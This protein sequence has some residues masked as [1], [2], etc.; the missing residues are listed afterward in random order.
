MKN[1][2]FLLKIW[3]WRELKGLGIQHLKETYAIPSCFILVGFAKFILLL[4][5]TLDT[6]QYNLEIFCHSPERE[7]QIQNKFGSVQNSNCLHIY[8]IKL[9]PTEH[10]FK[11]PCIMGKW[12]ALTR[13]ETELTGYINSLLLI[14]LSPTFIKNN[15]QIITLMIP[16]IHCSVQM[17]ASESHTLC[18]ITNIKLY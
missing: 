8:N 14:F 13:S 5:G 11:L 17:Y 2:I 15:K 9:Y 1:N 12:N 7:T 6:G 18:F 4:N 16:E 10:I 3:A